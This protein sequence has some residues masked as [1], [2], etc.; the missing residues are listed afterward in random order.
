MKILI[1]LCS[2]NL[3]SAFEEGNLLQYHSPL[4]QLLSKDAQ[5]FQLPML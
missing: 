4:L 1:F 3:K 2:E 5:P